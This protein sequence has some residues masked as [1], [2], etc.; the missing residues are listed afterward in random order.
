MAAILFLLYKCH[1]KA[2][3]IFLTYKS[4]VLIAAIN[5]ERLSS[6]N[7]LE[8]QLDKKQKQIK[9]YQNMNG[10]L[11]KTFEHLT[12]EKKTYVA[13]LLPEKL[14]AAMKYLVHVTN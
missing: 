3:Q 8:I 9:E 1:D 11:V 7:Y 12:V 2:E 6:M 13:I 4:N 5:R 14:G 10:N